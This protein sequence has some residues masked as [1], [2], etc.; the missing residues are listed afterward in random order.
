MADFTYVAVNKNGEQV[1]STIQAKTIDAA[2]TALRTDGLTPISV[3]PQSIFQKDINIGGEKKVTTR[4]LSVFCR[5][6]N[7]MLNAGVTVVQALDMLADQTENKTLVKALKKTSESVQQGD[8]LASAMAKSP[9]VF[10][11]MFVN[12]V[13]AGEV[14][15]SL[16]VCIARMGNQFEKSAKLAATMKS[17]L[18]YP[19]AVVVIALVV[20]IVMSTVV[21][22]QFAEMFA[23]MGSELPAATRACMALSDFLIHKWWLLLI[24]VAAVVIG[25][26]L[27]LKTDAGKTFW[28]TLAIKVPVLGPVNVKTSSA[29]FSRTMSTLVSS[30]MGIAQSLEVVGKAMKNILYKRALM[31][32]KIEVEQGV[33][34]SVPIRKS[35]VFP[36]LVPNM[37][38]IG[39]ETGSV[40]KMLDKVAEYFEEEA[41]AAT[42]QMSALMQP[43]IIVLL[44]G[45]VGWMVLAM[46]SPMINMY[47]D[48]GN[49]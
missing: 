24:I 1:K 16:E 22:P 15:G 35:G 9:K 36:V 7:S 8:S 39:E 28:G 14:S 45:I 3:K 48:I 12:L 46:Y 41:D 26:R 30:G 10:S 32:A 33:N 44:G 47:Q 34:L 19:I 38:A 29:S 21:V 23:G 5:Q 11:E 6:F 25:I 31:K 18:I 20:L 42:E 17:A 49:L 40:E 2:R 27:S 37:I 43:I 4:D 13:D